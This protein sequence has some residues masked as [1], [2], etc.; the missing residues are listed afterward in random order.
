MNSDFHL[1]ERSSEWRLLTLLARTAPVPK[2]LEEAD[3]LLSGRLDEREFF[4]LVAQFELQTLIHQN[5]HRHFPNRVSDKLSM[6]LKEH[7]SLI[8]AYN[9]ACA[10]ELS[11]LVGALEEAGIRTLTFKGVSLAA[12][13]YG[14]VS[15]RSFSDLDLLVKADQVHSGI[16]LLESMSYRLT[17]PVRNMS[18]P[19]KSKE[20][21]LI[22]PT[23]SFNVDLHWRLVDEIETQS[24]FNASVWDRSF[25]IRISDRSVRTLNPETYLIYLCLHGNRHHWASLKWICDIAQ[26]LQKYPDLDFKRILDECRRIGAF[27][28][29]GIG[30]LLSRELLGA[31]APEEAILPFKAQNEVLSLVHHYKNNLLHW[32]NNARLKFYFLQQ[33]AARERFRERIPT[34][35]AYLELDLKRI[36]KSYFSNP[37]L[38]R[39]E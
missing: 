11:R 18:F 25:E 16:R 21:G 39:K 8:R 12:L 32:K 15:L 29:L 35:F 4:Q 27:R 38:N 7:A 33:P 36:L 30:L 10:R 28:R 14:D 5:L 24:G 2:D 23:D 17:R 9:Y 37:I 26:I 34:F 31:E 3:R 20:T 1:D 19:K 22:D 6:R 13:A